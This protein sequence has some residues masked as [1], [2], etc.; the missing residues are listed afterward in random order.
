MGMYALQLVDAMVRKAGV[1]DDPV[2]P[3]ATLADIPFV[4]AFVIRHPSMGAESIQRFFDNYDEATSYLKSINVL[5][6]DFKYDDVANL[7]PYS[8]YQAVDGPHKALSEIMKA[9]DFINKAPDMAP[10]EKRQV[11][12]S[13]YFQAVEIAK[14]GNQ[15]FEALQDDIEKLKGRAEQVIPDPLKAQAQD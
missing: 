15:V 4:R 10:D 8:V 1:V 13:M 14:F 6:K 2:K 7:L 12:D 3:A 5:G 11:I 9:I